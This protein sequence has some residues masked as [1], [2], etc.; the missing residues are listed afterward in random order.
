MT[1]VLVTGASGQLG[2]DIVSVLKRDGIEVIAPTHDEMDIVDRDSV[3]RIFDTNDID[4]VVHCAAWTAVDLAEDEPERCNEVNV[5]G[6]RNIADCCRDRDIPMMYFS[7]DY[8][9]NGTGDRPWEVDDATDPI[10][11]YGLSKLRGE[12]SVRGLK[13]HYIIRISWVF[14][15]NGKNFVKT[16]INFSRTRP[17]VNVVDDQIGSPTYTADLAI[18]AVNVLFSGRYGTYHAHN[19]GYCSWYEFAKAIFDRIGSQITVAPIDTASFP[20][21][22]KRPMNSRMS[23]SSLSDNDFELL[24]SWEDALDRF[25]K[26]SEL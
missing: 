6:T 17:S 20:M 24:P 10:N 11:T 5:I 13:R 14:G 16:M 9:F 2:H 26:E 3:L 21:K 15:L 7:T 1:T 18:L 25:L 19:T 4:H 22:A 23:L 12:E 8:V